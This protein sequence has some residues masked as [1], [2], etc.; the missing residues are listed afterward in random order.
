VVERLPYARVV[1]IYC[2]VYGDYMTN[3]GTGYQSNLWDRIDSGYVPDAY[4]YT[5][6]NAPTMPS[7]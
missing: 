3:P 5:G 1:R 6:T 7:C 4:L 2:T